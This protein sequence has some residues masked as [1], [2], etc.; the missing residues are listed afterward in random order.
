MHISFSH[1]P[2]CD[3]G[4]FDFLMDNLRYKQWIYILEDVSWEVVLW[5][6]EDLDFFGGLT[7]FK[8]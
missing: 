2:W 5:E 1:L 7:H 4:Y 6:L 8:A 3:Q